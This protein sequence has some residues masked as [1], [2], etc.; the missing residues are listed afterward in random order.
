MKPMVLTAV[1]TLAGTGTIQAA[2][3]RPAVT[4]APAVLAEALRRGTI[5]AD[6]A[7]AL[8]RWILEEK[9]DVVARGLIDA[10]RSADLRAT[11]SDGEPWNA[12]ARAMAGLFESALDDAAGRRRHGAAQ[13]SELAAVVDAAAPVIAQ[14]LGRMSPSDRD[15]VMRTLQAVAPS[16]TPM[17]PVLARALR[18][19]RPEVRRAAALALGAMG[20]RARRAVADLR[21]A[22]D[23]PDPGV[24]AAAANA[25]RRVGAT[26][27]R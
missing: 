16:A 7:A 9:D 4:E 26:D 23:D 25:L 15:A 22:L 13:W 18:H 27:D 3:A 6:A 17:L 11:G 2:D 1:L 14:E 10:L 21:Q 12:T 20:P 24:R 8:T 19:D 5:D